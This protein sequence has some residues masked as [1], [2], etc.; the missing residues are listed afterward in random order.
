VLIKI[1]VEIFQRQYLFYVS[2]LKSQKKRIRF[3]GIMK[4]FRTFAA[5]KERVDFLLMKNY[6]LTIIKLNSND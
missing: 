2:N 1:L 6:F 5:Q 4:F 3:I